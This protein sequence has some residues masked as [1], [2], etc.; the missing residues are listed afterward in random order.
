EAG[1]VPPRDPLEEQLAHIW[2][3][4]L[5]LDRVGVTEDFF[6]LGGDSLDAVRICAMLERWLRVNLPLTEI[7][8]HPTI[9]SLADA[10]RAHDARAARSPVVLLNAGESRLPFFCV[11]GA[12]SD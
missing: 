11:P 9:A 3:K 6:D 10:V 8:R 4:A 5:R 2:A 12:G 7:A 1:Y